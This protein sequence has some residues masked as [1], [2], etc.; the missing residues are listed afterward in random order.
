MAMRGKSRT[1][2]AGPSPTTGPSGSDIAWCGRS[3][4]QQPFRLLHSEIVALWLKSRRRLNR[5]AQ[6]CNQAHRVPPAGIVRPHAGE[7]TSGPAEDLDGRA[8][9]HAGAFMIARYVISRHPQR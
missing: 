1:T 5:L 2:R 3:G 9:S 4:P 6:P 8:A 7:L